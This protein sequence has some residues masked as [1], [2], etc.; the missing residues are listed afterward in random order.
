[1]DVFCKIYIILTFSRW[2]GLKHWFGLRSYYW[3]WHETLKWAQKNKSRPQHWN[4]PTQTYGLI[5][6]AEPKFI[7]FIWSNEAISGWIGSGHAWTKKFGPPSP[8]YRF[9]WISPLVWVL[10]LF[11]SNYFIT[12]HYF[13]NTIYYL[14][15]L[16]IISIPNIL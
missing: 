4:R 1:M 8:P 2:I 13:S 16:E 15:L 7:G 12:I 14:L 3:F 9:N 11:G 6:L 5:G 10:D